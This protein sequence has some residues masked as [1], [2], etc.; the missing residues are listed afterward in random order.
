MSE[1]PA[2][3][4]IFGP[5][6][7]GLLSHPPRAVL[8]LSTIFRPQNVNTSLE[9][10]E[11]LRDFTGLELDQVVAFRPER[12]VVHELLI[13][14]MADVAVS[15]GTEIED[16][17][18]NFRRIA[19][20]ILNDR[21]T[22]AMPE[23][24]AAFDAFREQVRSIAEHE[25]AG[26]RG[27]EPARGSNDAG[28]SRGPRGWL[29]SWLGRTDGRHAR[30]PIP[31]DEIDELL[32]A[33]WNS[34]VEGEN[35]LLRI[36]VYR[37]LARV[38]SAIH[39]R[40][41]RLPADDT[42]L[43]RLAVDLV[44]NDQGSRL[45]GERLGPMIQAAAESDGFEL[46]PAQ[47]SPVVMNT[48]G[49]S[50]SG[51][52][53]MRP[54]QH[55]LA[56]RI[57]VR[58]GDFA[59]ISPDI[60]R[61]FLLDY[62]SLGEA[63]KYAGALTGHEVQIIDQKLDRYMAEKARCGRMS[64]LLIDRFRF[65]S[66][67]PASDEEGSNLLSRFGRTIY[68]FFMITPPELTVE[69]AWSRGLEVGR[70]KSVDDI[71]HHNIEAYTG[72]PQLFYTWALRADRKVHYEFLDNSVAR[73][74]TPRTIAFGWNREMHIL[75][76]RGMI[77]IDR[78]RRINVE[79]RS[80]GDV[81]RAESADAPESNT[82]FL[83]ACVR[84]LPVVQLVDRTTGVIYA[85]LESGVP[86]WI[87]PAGL[88]SASEDKE[89]RAVLLSLLDGKAPGAHRHRNDPPRLVDVLGQDRIHTIGEWGTRT[90][91]P[92]PDQVTE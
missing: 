91:V 90:E 75:D 25:L 29:R 14:V 64:H 8:Q 3:N 79:A 51:K 52:S 60:W 31:S 34:A 70:Y 89:S 49:A 85:R 78:F 71:L 55:R 1:L 23:F 83:R 59:L 27:S 88:E 36:A 68:L 81:Y 87:F 46:L 38:A 18:I 50:A 5:W 6:N 16:L 30:K 57:G 48:K 43:A 63:Y 10:A 86:V 15:D 42:V 9:Q 24:I 41:G 17:G 54:R 65:D 44:C 62:A 92:L 69:R 40:H 74:E 22:P 77:N 2:G 28:N 26:R 45:L 21:V 80:P 67:A 12:L 32:I 72:M 13:R 56:E 73:G 7:P 11:D 19:S 37:C 35:D 20:R 39:A 47:A 76:L 33:R 66:F 4:A 58:W 84:R 82:R 61:K 53:T